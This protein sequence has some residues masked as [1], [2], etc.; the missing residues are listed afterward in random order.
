MGEHPSHI[1]G[2]PLSKGTIQNRDLEICTNNK[3][4]LELFPG[5]KVTS[6]NAGVRKMEPLNNLLFAD[7]FDALNQF[8]FILDEHGRVTRAN[9]AVQNLISHPQEEIQGIPIWEIPWSVFSKAD[10]LSIK[11]AVEQAQRGGFVRREL[12]VRQQGDLKLAID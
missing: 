6:E 3:T 2:I 12:A 10:L 9:Q 11:Q 8:V 5:N 1:V 7:I 4:G